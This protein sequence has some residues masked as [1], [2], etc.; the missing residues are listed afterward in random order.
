MA[1][2]TTNILLTGCTGFIGGSILSNLLASSEPSLRDACITCLLRG[3]D[4]AEKL[5]AVY[6]KRVRPV[7]YQG[8][9]DVETTAAVAAE[10]DI[11]IN[12]TLGIHSASSQALVRGLAQR[13]ATTGRDVWIIHTSGTS[14]IADRPIS[15]PHI[16]VRVFDDIVD[17]VYGHEK[18]LEQEEMYAQ[19]TA[20]LGVVDEGL[21]LGVKTLIIMSPAIYGDGS[22][23]FKKTSMQTFRILATLKMKRAFVVS[24]GDNTYGHV[25]IDDLA[26]LYQLA[27]IEILDRAGEAIPTGK[28]SIIFSA[29]GEGTILEQAELIA[30]AAQEQRLLPE[31][32]VH[33]LSLEEAAHQVL[34]HLGLFTDEQ[35]AAAGPGM[36]EMI[37]ASNARTI[38]TVASKL[39]W[40]PSRGEDAWEKA[41]KDD[42]KSI[43]ESLG[44]VAK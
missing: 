4:R 17:D 39:G 30:A 22:G 28:K 13:K 27:L 34:P 20:E 38:P 11:V 43:A 23:L 5:T 2:T 14:N 26:D 1:A 10:H 12:T 31:K 29:T 8:L 19:R 7:L 32:R 15:Q 35:I 42:V 41:I 36:V 16:P 24:D 6:G 18:A 40:K 33:R 21:A 44:L 3:A 25:H 9:D 37:L